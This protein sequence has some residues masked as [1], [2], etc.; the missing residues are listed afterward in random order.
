MVRVVGLESVEGG[1]FSFGGFTFAGAFG[2]SSSDPDF[3]PRVDLDGDGSIGF[4]DFL[5]FA[6]S[7]G[8]R[9]GG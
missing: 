9:V 3:K 6:Q 8:K 4:G 1:E 5:K 2:K 7:F